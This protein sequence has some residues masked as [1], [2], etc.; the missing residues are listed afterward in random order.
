MP[1][2]SPQ[3]ARLVHVLEM[4]A[5]SGE[6]GRTL[7]ELS[8]SLGVDKATCR[9]MLVE[10]TNSGYLVRNSRSRTFHLGPRLVEI[11]RAAEH[12]VNVVDLARNA[13]SAL[14][15]RVGICTMAITPSADDLIIADV[16]PPANG[17]T[18]SR[19]ALGLRVGDRVAYRPPLGAI[20]AASAAPA[21]FQRWCDYVPPHDSDYRD[22]L[23][24][25]ITATRSRG[26]GVEQ[27][28]P[29]P[30]ELATVLENSAGGQWG[31]SR[32]VVLDDQVAHL[33]ADVMVG[34]I[35]PDQD[36]WPFSISAVVL[37]G[38]GAVATT[39][40]LVDPE[41]PMTG[42]RILELGKAVVAAAQ[43]V[44]DQLCS[45]MPHR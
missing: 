14:A 22:L 20:I 38:S 43:D 29:S 9:P 37:D 31:A 34:A 15:D 28:P 12:A 18:R 3:T 32:A 24:E 27:F 25:T 23:N 6:S 13:L 26:F 42:H 45:T 39:L 10:L 41:V 30:D 4:L 8:R 16:V 44:S 33:P 40:C 19:R 21:D 1:R 7:A 36:Y 11:G 17:T 35:A 5:A 2:S